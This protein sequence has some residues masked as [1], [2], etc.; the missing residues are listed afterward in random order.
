MLV[1]GALVLLVLLGATAAA[2]LRP[3][4]PW[5]AAAAA[6]ALLWP[7]VNRRW[8]GPVLWVPL[9]GHG[10]TAGDLLT[11]LAAALLAGRWIAL[12]RAARSEP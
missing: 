12:R 8:E 4:R 3:C 5:F 1:I 6:A 2:L 9:P 11:P 10:L 7:F